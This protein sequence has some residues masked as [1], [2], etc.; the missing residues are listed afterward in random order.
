MAHP[1]YHR[2]DSLDAALA[3]LRDEGPLVLAGGTDIYP[4]RAA[5]T[6]WMRPLPDRPVLDISALPGLRGIAD[7]GEHWR[8]GALVTWAALRDAAWLPPCFD[9]LRAAA[10]QIGGVQVQNRATLLGNL[11]NASPAADGVPPLLTLGAV[12]ELASAARGLRRLPLAAFVLGNRR[13]ALAP[14]ELATGL[15]IPKRPPDATRGGFLKL[16]ARSHLVISIAMVA[17]VLDSASGH[18]TQARLAV[19]ACSAVAQRLLQA[20]AA[21]IG[22]PLAGPALAAAL[23]PRHLAP[24]DPIDDMRASADYRRTAALVLLRRLLAEL[25]APPGRL[26][27]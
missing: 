5:A 22:L 19:G 25:A 4:A 12:V 18:V 13:T 1:A 23:H 21:L 11:C 8:L 26:A 24:I 17:A 15:L 14:D 16:G 7:A 10:G 3:L 6:A 2:P 20:E 9:G 27:A